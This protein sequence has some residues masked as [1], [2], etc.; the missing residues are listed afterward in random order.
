MQVV[1][2]STRSQRRRHH[3]HDGAQGSQ[4][5]TGPPPTIGIVRLLWCKVEI[6]L[7]HRPEY[8][9]AVVPITSIR[10]LGTT[11]ARRASRARRVECLCRQ[12]LWR[13]CYKVHGLHGRAVELI[14]VQSRYVVVWVGLDLIGFEQLGLRVA[15]VDCV[16]V[17]AGRGGELAAVDAEGGQDYAAVAWEGVCSVLPLHDGR[18]AFR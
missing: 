15:D 14:Q 6:L 9:L 17:L 5:Y 1:L 10:S 16:G 18:G 4:T 3:V 2:P 11:L 7:A 8:L 12:H 13:R